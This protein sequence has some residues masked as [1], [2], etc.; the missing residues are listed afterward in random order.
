MEPI[1]LISLLFNLTS[2]NLVNHELKSN[3][4]LTFESVYEAKQYI[5]NE[6]N[7]QNNNTRSDLVENYRI[8]MIN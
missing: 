5:F 7:F 3:S 1:S 6:N 2:F 4:N 8:A